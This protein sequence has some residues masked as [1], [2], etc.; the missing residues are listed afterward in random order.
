MLW[1]QYAGMQLYYT[2]KPVSGTVMLK[3]NLFLQNSFIVIFVITICTY[4]NFSLVLCIV[5]LSNIFCFL[6]LNYIFICAIL[7]VYKN[8]TYFWLFELFYAK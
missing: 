2:L 4:R 5:Y 8:Y 7:K 3:Y 6:K 1:L